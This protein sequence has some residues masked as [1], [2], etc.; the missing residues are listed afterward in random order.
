MTNRDSLH[1][2]VSVADAIAALADRGRAGAPL[3]GATWIMRAPIRKDRHDY[4]Y[5]AL[6]KI[7]ELRHVVIRDDEL[8]IGACATHAQLA[9]ALAPLPEFQ[10][11]AMAAGGSANPA[12]R[13]IATIGGNIC[14]DGFSASDLVPA[15]ICLD[16]RVELATARGDECVPI[17]KFLAMRSTLDSDCL[18]RRVIVPRV[19]CRS[20]HVRLTLRKAGDYPVAIV[21]LA[22]DVSPTGVVK[23]ARVAIGSVEATARRWAHLEEL[24]AGH[25][26][27]PND[28]AEKVQCCIG[29]F[30]GR[31]GIEVPSWYRIQVLPALVRKAVYAIQRQH[32]RT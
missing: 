5:V 6:T 18:V 26:L 23:R 3:A 28:V 8:S 15:L 9:A 30:R 19:P 2:A 29:E 27:D 14:A 1:V 7:G 20:T 32:Q 22:A 24:L 25:P 11:L 13:Q 16:A 12:I 4:S 10:A 17:T 21:S 31:D